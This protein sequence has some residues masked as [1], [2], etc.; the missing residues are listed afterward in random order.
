MIRAKGHRLTVQRQLILDAV[1]QAGGHAS[2]D[3]IHRIV[4][5]RAP[6][7]N[8]A[9]VYRALNFLCRLGLVTST[10][11]RHGRLEY[12]IA[13]PHPHHHLICQ[14]CATRVELPHTQV[15]PLLEAIKEQFD[16][17]V[18]NHTHLSLF[19]LCAQCQASAG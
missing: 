19:G 12:E 7:I 8:R 10:L 11:G 4:Q 1:C 16:F 3:D 18:A 13:G 5:R 14:Q 6:A 17:Q 15:A 2:P 9:T